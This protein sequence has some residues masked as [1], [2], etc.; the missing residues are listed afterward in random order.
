MSDACV[1]GWLF[2]SQIDQNSATLEGS[3]ASII[4]PLF[5][6]PLTVALLPKRRS[7][8]L[9]DNTTKALGMAGKPYRLC[10]FGYL[11]MDGQGKLDGQR[12]DAKVKFSKKPN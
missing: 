8:A 1:T 12:D 11:L 3:S 6:R 9:T 5:Q 7:Y 2:S 4:L 10:E